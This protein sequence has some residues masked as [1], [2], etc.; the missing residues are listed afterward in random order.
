MGW[1]GAEGR[2]SGALRLCTCIY[3]F[4]ELRSGCRRVGMSERER[5]RE[6]EKKKKTHHG[7]WADDGSG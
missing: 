2:W 3:H 7:M 4:G 1:N 5:E 6:R